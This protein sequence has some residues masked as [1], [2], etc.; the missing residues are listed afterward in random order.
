MNI[1]YS[2]DVINR[3]VNQ[4]NVGKDLGGNLWVFSYSLTNAVPIAGESKGN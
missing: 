3:G 2:N 1:D 4:A